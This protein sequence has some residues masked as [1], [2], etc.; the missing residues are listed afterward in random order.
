MRMVEGH[1]WVRDEDAERKEKEKEGKGSGKDVAGSSSKG[2]S[3][4]KPGS[5]AGSFGMERTESRD[6]D[7]DDDDG[8]EGLANGDRMVGLQKEKETAKGKESGT[9]KVNGV[10]ARSN[11]SE[12]GMISPESLEAI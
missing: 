1:G 6:A 9:K 7:G 10:D 11:T 8:D 12:G 3:K 5:A 4:L 2:G